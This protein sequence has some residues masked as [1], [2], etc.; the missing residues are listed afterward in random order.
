MNKTREGKP[1]PRR[2]DDKSEHPCVTFPDFYIVVAD[3]EKFIHELD[4]LC[5]KHQVDGSWGFTFDTE[6]V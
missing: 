4:D 5:K 1:K 6:A 3:V 2:F